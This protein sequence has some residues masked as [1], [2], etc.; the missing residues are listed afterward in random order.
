[1]NIKNEMQADQKTKKTS[2]HS[3]DYRSILNLFITQMSF[4]TIQRHYILNHG[5]CTLLTTKNMHRPNI[6]V[7]KREENGDALVRNGPG[8]V[9]LCCWRR[10][11]EHTCAWKRLAL[12]CPTV[13]YNT[14][15]CDFQIMIYRQ[16]YT[17]VFKETR[18]SKIKIFFAYVKSTLL[19]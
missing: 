14:S 12:P 2:T 4:S 15:A 17:H 7:V 3:L 1:M 5:L 19:G 9:T 13:L 11:W 8:S 18:R 10:V 16:Y 6:R